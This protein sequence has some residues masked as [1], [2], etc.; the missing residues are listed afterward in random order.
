MISSGPSL[1]GAL[2]ALEIFP[3]AATLER[4]GWPATSF[5]QVM[6]KLPVACA[7]SWSNTSPS[8]QPSVWLPSR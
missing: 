1:P 7:A 6:S 8:V 2:S 4:I 5:R 3:Q